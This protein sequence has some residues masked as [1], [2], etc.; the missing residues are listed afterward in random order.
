MNRHDPSDVDVLSFLQRMARSGVTF[1]LEGGRLKSAVAGELAS[2][3]R[4]YVQRNKAE[5]IAHLLSQLQQIPAA[6]PGDPGVA[7]M[8]FQQERLWLLNE[9]AQRSEEYNSVTAL[10]IHGRFDYARFSRALTRV[11]SEN[12]VLRTIFRAAGGAVR[13]VILDARPSITR[14][15]AGSPQDALAAADSLVDAESNHQFDLGNDI[16]VRCWV[17][18]APDDLHYVVLN[19]HHIACD[20]WSTP[21]I[22]NQIARYYEAPDLAA[23]SPACSY[24]DYAR[25]QRQT[26]TGDVLDTLV[27]RW[28][29]R[30]DGAPLANSLPTDF[31]PGAAE[32]E[33]PGAA[34]HPDYLYRHQVD[35][36]SYTAFT[37]ACVRLGA[38]EFSGLH[39]VLAILV[40]ILSGQ[41]ETIV[42]SPIANR[43]QGDV[44]SII[45]F[46]VNMIS[47]RGTVLPDSTFRD[48]LAAKMG[49]IEFGYAFQ[50]VP[51]ERIVQQIA[52]QR[53]ESSPVFQIVLA[54]QNYQ[55]TQP[56][57][58]DARVSRLPD[59]QQHNRFDLEVFVQGSGTQDRELTWV[60]NGRLFEPATVQRWAAWFTALLEAVT[61][62]P[63]LQVAE[64]RDRLAAETATGSSATPARTLNVVQCIQ[65]VAEADPNRIAV[66]EGG[67]DETYAALAENGRRIGAALAERYGPDAVFALQMDR[68]VELVQ[69]IVGIMSI[70]AA[71]VVLDPDDSAARRA[72][73]LEAS[74][75]ACLLVAGN[76]EP[77][78]DDLGID[79]TDVRI[80]EPTVQPAEQ[81][82][83]TGRDLYYVFT[84]GSTGR[85]KGVRVTYGNLAAYL[86]GVVSRLRLPYGA[87]HCW[88]SSVATDFGNT[89]L[90]GALATGGRL[91]IATRDDILDGAAMRGFLREHATDILKITPTHLEALLETHPVTDLLPARM[92]ILGGEAASPAVIQALRDVPASVEVYNHYGPSE[93]TVGVLV[94]DVA[95]REA[96]GPLPVGRPLA[97]VVLSIEAEDGH[98]VPFGVPGEL[99][100]RGPQVADGYLAQPAGAATPFFEAADGRGY[101]TGDWVR[102]RND[103]QVVF[104][105][106]R[107]NQVKVR[108]YRVELGEIKAA[109]ELAPGVARGEVLAVREP[110]EPPRLVA[111]VQPDESGTGMPPE[112]VIDAES[113]VAEWREFYDY[114][115]SERVD[116]DI[117]FNT[118][119]WISSYSGEKIPDEQMRDW[120]ATTIGRIEA[121]QPRN[122]LEIGCGL[123]IIAYPLSRSV[124]SYLACDFS[125]QI[126]AANQRN[127]QQVSTGELSFFVCEAIDID[128]HAARIL[129]AGVDTVIVNSV[130]QYFP[131]ADYLEEVLDKLLAIDSVRNVFVGDVRNYDLLDEFSLS[132]VDARRAPGEAASGIERLRLARAESAQV[133]E[134]LV[135][136]LFWGEFARAR[137]SVAGVSVLPRA[138]SFSNELLDFRYDVLLTKDAGTLHHPGRHGPVETRQGDLDAADRLWSD[139]AAGTVDTVV[140]RGV[141]NPQTAG[142]CERLRAARSGVAQAAGAVGSEHRE[143]GGQALRRLTDLAAAHGLRVTAHYARDE[144]GYA[145]LLD[146]VIFRADGPGLAASETPGSGQRRPGALFSTPAARKPGTRLASDVARHVALALPRHMRPDQVVEVPA[147]PLNKTGKIDHGALRLLIPR[148]DRS[149]VLG[150]VHGAVEQRLAEILGGLLTSGEPVDRESDFF[151]IGGHSLLAI[152]Y[153]H[154]VNK[155]FGLDLRVKW[156]FDRPRLRDFAELVAAQPGRKAAEAAS[157]SQAP[158]DGTAMSP[159]QQRF[160]TVARGSGPSTLYNS[161]MLLELTGQVSADSLRDAFQQVLGHHPILR[162]YFHE[163]AGRVLLRQRDPGDFIL[164]RIEAPGLDAA[165]AERIL[166]G[167]LN[168]PFALES[169]PLLEA[170]LLTASPGT[171]FLAMSIHHII[172]DGASDAIFLADLAECYAASRENREPRWPDDGRGFFAY[173]AE[174]REPGP[175]D[176]EFWSRQLSGA[177]GTHA[178]PLRGERASAAAGGGTVHSVLPAGTTTLLA[179]TA[180]AHKTTPFVVLNA[181]VGLFIAFLSGADDVV[182]GSPV[183][184]RE[185][186][187]DNA[188]IGMY[189]NTVPVRHRIDWGQTLDDLIVAERDAFRDIFTHR[190]VPFDRIVEWVN[191]PRVPG[192]NP[193]FQIVLTLQP[194]G[195]R[196]FPFYD[197][198]ARS[199]KADTA[200][201]K[202]DLELNSKVVDGQLN[203][204]WEYRQDVF[205][206]ERVGQMAGLFGSF[207]QTV[208]TAPRLPLSAHLF[209]E[210]DDGHLAAALLA[211]LGQRDSGP[212]P[213][214]PAADAGARDT[215]AAD[216]L[217]V[218]W[219]EVLGVSDALPTDTSFFSLGGNSLALT[220]VMQRMNDEFGAEVTLDTL[221]RHS[222]LEEQTAL[223]AAGYGGPEPEPEAAGRLETASEHDEVELTAA[224]RRFYLLEKLGSGADYV[225][226]IC[227]RAGSGVGVGR[228]KDAVIALTDLHPVLKSR[229]ADRRGRLVLLPGAAVPGGDCIGDV[230]QCG[231]DEETLA[232]MMTA[233]ERAVN[234]FD[235]PLFRAFLY[236]QPD[237]AVRLQLLVHHVI[238]DGWSERVLLDDLARLYGDLAAGQ[239][240][241]RRAVPF[242]HYATRPADGRAAANTDWWIASL[243]GAPAAHSLPGPGRLAAGQEAIAHPVHRVLPGE[244]LAR[245]QDRCRDLGVTLFNVL[246]SALALAVLTMSYEDDVVIGVPTANRGDT[247]YHGTI[248]LFMET[249]PIRTAIVG[250]D[251][252]FS[253]ITRASLATLADAVERSDFRIEEVLNACAS[254][255]DGTRNALYQIMLSVS[256][257]SGRFLDLAGEP[258]ERFHL[259]ARAPKL[260]LVLNAKVVAGALH[261]FWEYD[262]GRL[263]DSTVTALVGD[264]EH[265]LQWGLDQPDRPIRERGATKPELRTADAGEPGGPRSVYERFA[266]AWDARWQD[267]AFTSGDTRLTAGQLHGRVVGMADRL[268][269]EGVGRKS[270]VA[271]HSRQVLD[272]VITFL[273]SSRLGATHVPLDSANPPERAR[274]ILE[275]CD[276]DV[277]VSESPGEFRDYL[278][279]STAGL[280]EDPPVTRG[281]PS[282]P[283][284]VSHIIFT[285]GT[286]GKPKGVQLSVSATDSYVTSIRDACG[287]IDA[288][289]TQ[290]NNPAYDFFVEEMALSL[291]S[292][293]RMAVVPDCDRADPAAFARFIER[294]QAGTVTLTTGYW[295]FLAGTLSDADLS[296]LRGVRAF[297]VGGEDYPPEAARRWLGKLGVSTRLLN[298]YGPAENGP[299]SL[300]RELRPDTPPSAIGRPLGA[301][302]ASVRSRQGVVVPAGGRGELWLA[303]PQLF[304]G[305]V[306]ESGAGEYQTGDIV[307]CEGENGYRFVERADSMMKISGFRVET[308]EYAAP[309]GAVPGIAG[310][311]VTAAAARDGVLVYCLIDG[312]V[313]EE[314]ITADAERSLRAALPQYM[315]RYELR[316]CREIPLTVNGKV[317]FAALEKDS[318]PAPARVPASRDDQPAFRPGIRAAW[319][320]VLGAVQLDEDL[321]FF[322]HG[323]T[324]MS[325]LGLLTQLNERFP[326]CFELMDLFEKPTVALQAQHVHDQ[327][328]VR[329]EDGQAV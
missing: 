231:D 203:V 27:A 292:G 147:F 155:A 7:E 301:V 191:P 110:G 57:L 249:L 13:P 212:A 140:V 194:D 239:L 121:V 148:E 221:Y 30:L 138:S 88:H 310:V 308:G 34:E 42:G 210:G 68:S 315:R 287:A 320:Q 188:A 261:L 100:L 295:A 222:T 211:D 179:E 285:S 233:R 136:D 145:A 59:V 80:L 53:T 93:T 265:W 178:L 260:D 303:G 127:A 2:A 65:T 269:E 275:V 161:L 184:C 267:L 327:L 14:V 167:R 126:I 69:A 324:S 248:G 5:I 314:E 89:V 63:G 232:A 171:H 257:E 106:R 122:V 98:P 156:V 225:D 238:F 284:A 175:E 200:A 326:G 159:L 246:H 141:R 119:G 280:P 113:V 82:A 1:F 152:R 208:L 33:K 112:A 201:P 329:T 247:L 24:Q 262:G 279:L 104:L 228:L 74:E 259:P 182:T 250:G 271:C 97:G 103:G 272:H 277:V 55:E 120:L 10:A 198:T 17:V 12:E 263:S 288:P 19:V 298:T 168:R 52:D 163:E 108:G 134:L 23:A 150:Q 71:Y 99:V 67:R 270:V 118:S 96:S 183:D 160:W 116:G 223:L 36:A 28:C 6:G 296:R 72:M 54:L 325:M 220:T 219:Q 41:E 253:E 172:F 224:Q 180:R 236:V 47:V 66:T 62:D 204:Y 101:R 181:L 49:E 234:I 90:F 154:A 199:I 125:S 135:S 86:G 283:G 151:A 8:S 268:A 85:P 304:S 305:Y 158:A 244:I 202:F 282:R 58:G 256:D 321:G 115:Y 196:E 44:Q 307:L 15:P 215:A 56:R 48:V 77:A 293:N 107:D 230:I 143:P 186:E 51:F 323:G 218:I 32:P 237:G 226:S 92:L 174:V 205:S 149:A 176:R 9:I 164:A 137:E 146:V 300:V 40:A 20:G 217:S 26:L 187:T 251:L 128:R 255:R 328:A 131:S 273:A 216:R 76:R 94:A 241:P 177:P 266:A 240:T 111:F 139:L 169:G 173:L 16:P 130:V 278:S 206:G 83:A 311:R 170:A 11:V 87:R 37:E 213:D 229:V 185:T 35:A 264:F 132:L 117:E 3:D 84:S 21:L 31:T 235:G 142:H 46:F 25:W 322:D 286:T 43:E 197:C 18:S 258:A 91:D 312:K 129:D 245:L 289:V 252:T 290:C 61:Q 64:L 207:L 105:G 242:Q 254:H 192:A 294:E 209:T 79:V 39:A 319:T 157:R 281:R 316:F 153:I 190:A 306:G 297:L 144:G 193:V 102:Q 50:Q 195:A 95:A 29:D 189:V 73:V 313:P 109:V 162:S 38:N 60:Y 165:G 214:Q 318:W 274:R 133:A 123:G 276:A 317:D 166:S 124:D 81:P 291:L 70:G 75:P 243:T 227:F 302:R 4:E 22:W 309:L 78:A 114:A 45:G 299:V